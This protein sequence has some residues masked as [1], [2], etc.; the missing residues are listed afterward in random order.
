MSQEELNFAYP[1]TI[2]LFPALDVPKGAVFDRP[3]PPSSK[4]W[5]RYD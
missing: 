2:A 4:R 3:M 5:S 1:Q